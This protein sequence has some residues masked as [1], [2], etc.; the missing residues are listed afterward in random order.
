VII[1]FHPDSRQM[2][3][4]T[5]L[6][7]VIACAFLV[8]AT[9]SS[10]DNSVSSTNSGTNGADSSSTQASTSVAQPAATPAVQ[11]APGG[12]SESSEGTN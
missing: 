12:N 1:R 10:A 2:Q 11:S 5:I 9:Q 3:P 7:C 8:F 6:F 4:T